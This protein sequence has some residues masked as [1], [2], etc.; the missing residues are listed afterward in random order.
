[1]RVFMQSVDHAAGP[2]VDITR[3]KTVRR[4]LNTSRRPARSGYPTPK[5]RRTWVGGN[6]RG[7]PITGSSPGRA[8]PSWSAGL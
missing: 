6:R 3:A 4:R 8:K 7:E 5:L 2:L 1:M